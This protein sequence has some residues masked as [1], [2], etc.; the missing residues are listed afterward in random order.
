L[1]LTGAGSDFKQEAESPNEESRITNL[2]AGGQLGI[3]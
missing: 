1:V 2:N 3:I